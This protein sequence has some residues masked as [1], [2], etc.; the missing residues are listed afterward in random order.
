MPDHGPRQAPRHDAATQEVIRIK[1]AKSVLAGKTIKEV[2]EI[3]GV[4]RSAVGNWSRKARQHG[5]N[6]L[7]A[8]SRGRRHGQ[9]RVL[10]SQQEMRIQ[11]WIREKDPQQFGLPFKRW[12]SRAVMALVL[13]RF[14][15]AMPRRTVQDYLY[16]WNCNARSSASRPVAKKS[17][18][19]RSGRRLK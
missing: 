7:K 13:Q 17:D 2:A 6:S 19:K 5:I 9:K 4:S 11:K 14:K 1:A 16:R 8:V 3:F 10:D 12:E 18:A 15:I